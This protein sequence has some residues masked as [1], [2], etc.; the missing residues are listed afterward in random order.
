[1]LADSASIA[2]LVLGILGGVFT[3]VGTVLT[4]F[5]VTAF[6][7]IPFAIIGI[8]MLLAGG[9]LLNTRYQEK[10]KIVNVLRYGQAM[11]GEIT[12]VQENLMV[13]VNH[14]HPWIIEYQF[15]ANGQVYHGSA[16]TYRDPAAY[17]GAQLQPGKPVYVLYQPDAPEQNALYPHP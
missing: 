14:R 3:L 1:M 4:L 16:L 11:R 6:V 5:M 10:Q 2:G 13:R 8:P 17:A 12:G 7:G 15:R 9:G